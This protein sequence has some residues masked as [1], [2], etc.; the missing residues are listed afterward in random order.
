MNDLVFILINIAII[1]AIMKHDSISA[2]WK[3]YLKYKAAAPK[4]LEVYGKR[5]T[6]MGK[7]SAR[8]MLLRDLLT[9]EIDD[10]VSWTK[11]SCCNTKTWQTEEPWQWKDMG[12]SS[13]LSKCTVCGNVDRW[14]EGPGILIQVADSL[15]QEQRRKL[16]DAQDKDEHANV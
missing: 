14:I 4:A 7:N 8:L 11:C 3:F 15:N 12:D 6:S 2:C 9:Q 13:I 10:Q 5:S 1:I 16:F